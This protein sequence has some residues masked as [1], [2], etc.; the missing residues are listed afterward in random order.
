MSNEI[1]FILT[2][3]AAELIPKVLNGKT[4][5]FTRMAV[6]DGFSY[7]ETVAKGFTT[8]VNE[9]LSLDITKKE[10]LTPS[11]VKIT[12][13]FKNTDAQNEF[14]YRE[15]GLFA[16]DPDTGEEVL[17]AYGN[18]NDAAEFITPTGSSI[19][20]KQLI[21]VTTVG[22]SANVTFNINAD[23][24]ALQDDMLNVQ[25]DIEQIQSNLNQAQSNI[26]KG[27]TDI[28]EVQ[29]DLT[30]VQ[31]NLINLQ[32]GKANKNL[33]NT[34]MIT[35]CLLE[36]P[37][38]VKYELSNGVLIIKAGTVVVVPYGVADLTT[39]Y[40]IGSTFIHANF[41]VVETQYADGKFFVW[42]EL[43][44][45]ISFSQPDTR[46]ALGTI[47][48]QINNNIIWPYALEDNPYFYYD[49]NTNM[50]INSQMSDIVHSLPI[51]HST[52]DTTGISSV[53]QVFNGIGYM[54]STVWVDKGVKGLIPDGI[55]HDGTLKNIEYTVNDLLIYD[56]GV[57]GFTGNALYHINAKG[58]LSNIDSN[59][60]LSNDNYLI[61]PYTKK[62]FSGFEIAKG[63]RTNG[64]ITSLKPS[65]PFK[66]VD[67]NAY[68]DKITNL[69]L[70]ISTLETNLNS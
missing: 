50:V 62:I 61:D 28:Q 16:Q 20:T 14:Y 60:S 67:Y 6:G 25:A 49:I 64:V 40:P 45:D 66:I 57:E 31:T 23:V 43:L 26:Q 38:T 4:L 10:I 47:P 19:V 70:R 46:S 37:Q 17:Y 44:N 29:S 33:S 5:N 18:R 35:N 21:F 24:Y 42:V 36:V 51:L 3:S 54:G 22:D 68:I 9:V 52:R 59:Y 58:Y 39:T 56:Y 12:S 53:N 8:L 27:Q 32:T 34:G 55:N 48:I 7:D 65:K 30:N 1:N 13:V 41:K 63:T 2:N 11:S 69:E 15:V